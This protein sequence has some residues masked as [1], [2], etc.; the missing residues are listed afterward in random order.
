ML[1][2]A[3]LAGAAAQTPPSPGVSVTSAQSANPGPM[4]PAVEPKELSGMLTAQNAV[5]SHL[6][7][8]RLIWSAELSDRATETANATTGRTCGKTGALRVGEAA[9]AAVYWAPPMRMFAGGDTAQEISSSYLVS[10]WQVGATDY[11][12]KTQQCRKGGVCMSYARLVDPEV[13]AVGCARKLCDS[14]A[15]I[16]VCHYGR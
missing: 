6:N 15:Q 7:L 13:R 8:S 4:R 5:R 12:A 10:E 16:W 2:L 1:A 14:Q 9:G 3:G 11:D